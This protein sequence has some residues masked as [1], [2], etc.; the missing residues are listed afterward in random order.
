MSDDMVAL[1][2]GWGSPPQIIDPATFAGYD[3]GGSK[4]FHVTRAFA[5]EYIAIDA[6]QREMHQMLRACKA[7]KKLQAW[8]IVLE[9]ETVAEG[10]YPGQR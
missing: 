9:D 2:T 3:G 4:I 5:E 10:V 8:R 6:R 1:D 7:Y